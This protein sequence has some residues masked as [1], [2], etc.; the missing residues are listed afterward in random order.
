MSVFESSDAGKQHNATINL[1]VSH[2]AQKVQ[3]PQIKSL[4]P[5]A[6]PSAFS[7]ANLKKS[8]WAK[9]SH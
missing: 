7:S 5:L 2:S 6:I 1:T 9:D 8:K 3:L 4:N